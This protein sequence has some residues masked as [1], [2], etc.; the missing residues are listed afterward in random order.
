MSWNQPIKI[1]VGVML[2]LAAT[3]ATWLLLTRSD[4]GNQPPVLTSEEASKQRVLAKWSEGPFAD[5]LADSRATLASNIRRSTRDPGRILSDVQVARFAEHVADHAIARSLDPKEC[6]DWLVNQP[7][8]RWIDERD[9]SSW[10]ILDTWHEHNFKVRA[11]RDDLEPV[12]RLVVNQQFSSGGSKFQGISPEPDTCWIL[13]FRARAE[14]QIAD[15][16]VEALGDEG[17]ARWFEANVIGALRM[18]VPERSFDAVLA[19]EGSVT[20]A[21]SCIPVRTHGGHLFNWYAEWY[22]EPS[23][24]MWQCLRMACRGWKGRLCL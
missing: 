13:V 24:S 3:S 18:R 20:L 17:L 4:A 15:S 21:V 1:V 19:D 22:W 9:P 14:N 23:S 2:A 7:G 12:M 11:P 8:T 16:L 6:V 10:S 5:L